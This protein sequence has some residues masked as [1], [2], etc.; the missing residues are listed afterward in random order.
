MAL[1]QIFNHFPKRFK[2]FKNKDHIYKVL[3]WKYFIYFFLIIIIFT[4]FIIVENLISQKNKKESQN[5]NS[6]VKSKEFSNLSNYFISKINSPYKEVKYLI[7]NNDSID[8]ILKKLDVNKN[9]IKIISNSLKQ[10]KTY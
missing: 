7:Q 2:N 10:K 1:N 9:D 5:L 6:I 4:I 3:N 8:K